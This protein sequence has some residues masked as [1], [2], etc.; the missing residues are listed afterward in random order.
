MPLQ[1][2]NQNVGQPAPDIEGSSSTVKNTPPAKPTNKSTGKLK[3]VI[4]MDSGDDD[5]HNTQTPPAG[6][7]NSAV[8]AIP[9]EKIKLTLSKK[10]S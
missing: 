6:P 8:K 4:A 1:S 2:T 5:D 10:Q 9:L 7:S 3:R